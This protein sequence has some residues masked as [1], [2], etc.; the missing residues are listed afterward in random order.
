MLSSVYNAVSAFTNWLWG[1]PILLILVGGGIIL[2]VIIGGIQFTKFGFIMRNTLGSLFDREEQRRKKALGVSPA[3]AVIAALGTTIGTGNIVGAAS[4]IALGGPGALFWMWVSGI[5]AMAIKYCEVTL[6][7]KYR[8][9]NDKGD[10]YLAGPFMYIKEGLHNIPLAYIMGA[11]M[12][13]AMTIVAGVHASSITAS[14]GSVGVPPWAACVLIVIAVLVVVIGGFKSLC[15]ITDVMVPV[16]TAFY[17]I[18]SLVVILANIGSI[19]AVLIAVFKGAFTG[20]AVT[21]GFVG[22]TLAATV[23]WGLAR[24]VFS[25]DAGL[26]LQAIMHAQA[27]SIEHP[28]AQGIWAIFETFVDTIVV[29]SL[30]GFMV[31]FTGVWESGA[32]GEAL[33]ATALSSVLGGFGRYGCTI[34]MVLFALSSMIGIGDAVKVQSLEISGSRLISRAA[35]AIFIG[36]VVASCLADIQAVFVFAD[37]GNGITLS[38]NIIAMILMGKVLRETTREWFDQQEKL[39]RK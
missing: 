15:R 5:V 35:Q 10:G 16:M 26:G 32:S 14:L 3:Q 12:L 29:C 18:C 39:S 38:I 9:K 34:A 23:R 25:N 21:G 24:G 27:D 19:G 2:T 4:A 22:A 28:A 13:I 33:A 36:V 17:L 7:V 1:I 11:S 37:L 30:T 6:S 31:L 8:R 20:W